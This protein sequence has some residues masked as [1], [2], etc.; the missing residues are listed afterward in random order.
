VG[1]PLFTTALWMFV[2]MDY[3][4]E[5]YEGFHYS[6]DMWLGALIVNFIWNALA[7]LE[8]SGND[9]DESIAT[10]KFYPLQDATTTDVL[11]YFLP[12]FGTYIQ[13]IGIVPQNLG[14]YT[15]ISYVIMV[16]FQLYQHGFQQY[17]QHIL[18]CLLYM[19]LGVYL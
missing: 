3:M 15:I 5:V 7:P 2:A 10:R 16:I 12:A 14:N 6:V 13:V 1:K 9:S 4:V 18:F 17:T 19:A 11:W 8:D